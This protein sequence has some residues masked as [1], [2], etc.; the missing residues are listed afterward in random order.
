MGL[1]RSES[2]IDRMRWVVNLLK[3]I[4][5]PIYWGYEP[6]CYKAR[7][8]LEEI[9]EGKAIEFERTR[10]AETLNLPNAFDRVDENDDQIFYSIDRFVDHL[11]S[12][13]LQTIEMVHGRVIIE[14]KPQI[15]DLMA[16]WNSHIPQG[17]NPKGVIG[18]GLNKN[19]L[20]ENKTLTDF[21]IHDLNK[22]PD[23]PFPDH[24]F[25]AVL[26]TVSVDYMIRPFEV[27]KEVGRILKPG[28]VFIV[29]FSNRMF[30]EKAVK[31][32]KESDEE[33]RVL[34]VEE[35]FEASGMFEKP[36]LFISKGKPRPKEDK[37]AST[38]LPSDPVF[39]IYADRQG[40]DPTRDDRPEVQ[41]AFGPRIDEASLQRRKQEIKETL[42]CPYCGVRLRKW[43]VPDNPFAATWDNDFMYICF[44]DACPYYVRG[45]DNMSRGG[46]RG[47]SYRL[48]YRPDKDTCGPI[49]VNTPKSL[50]EGIIE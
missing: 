1:I 27:F 34:L 14:A 41:L 40:G 38:G 6:G 29:S 2:H 26:N 45:W 21:V 43:E 8:F 49:P 13:A 17:I 46:N 12:Q 11:D 48:M 19:E 42:S 47:V 50:R 15:L 22:N 33:G 23:L 5:L 37:Y 31:I 24:F 44:N 39:V 7:F 18:L 20:M 30:P 9:M 10:Y 16:G 3:N 36:T 4:N 28:G 32:W 25:D 35:Y